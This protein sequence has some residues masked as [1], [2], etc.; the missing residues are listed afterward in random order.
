MQFISN[1]FADL[2]LADHR[3]CQILNC[4]FML[5]AQ[6]T[7]SALLEALRQRVSCLPGFADRGGAVRRTSWRRIR[8]CGVFCARDRKYRSY[9]LCS[10][11]LNSALALVGQ[12]VMYLATGV[13]LT[14]RSKEAEPQIVRWN[15]GFVTFS[16][17]LSSCKDL[18]CPWS[19]L[20]RFRQQNKAKSKGACGTLA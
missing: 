7:R 1:R 5:R 11:V 2:A 17:L 20:S 13:L 4:W 19:I 14:N 8:H 12:V 18:S 3:F 10:R 16:C 9:R 15:K 6:V